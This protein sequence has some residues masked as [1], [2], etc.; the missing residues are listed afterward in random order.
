MV[1]FATTGTP[2]LTTSFSEQCWGTMFMS[3]LRRVPASS[4]VI[5][6]AAIRDNFAC[7]FASL[8]GPLAPR[9]H[10][11]GSFFF[12]SHSK[13][14]FS[15]SARPHT[16]QLPRLRSSADSGDSG[17]LTR[18]ILACQSR[19]EVLALFESFQSSI[20]LDRIHISA[21]FTTLRKLGGKT[22]ASDAR[23]IKLVELAR[24]RFPKA[25]GRELATVIHR[26]GQLGAT[27]SGEWIAGFWKSSEAKL[28]DFSALDFSSTMHACSRLGLTPPQPWLAV[29]WKSSA[30]KLSGFDAKGLAN[31]LFAFSKLSLAPPQPWMDSFM[32]ALAI[33]KQ[34]SSPTSSTSS[35]EKEVH[36]FLGAAESKGAK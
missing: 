33:L 9:P 16:M 31:T 4:A 13:A 25:D 22:V 5:A 17:D 8:P 26:C 19:D 27:L 28:S 23:F 15:Q 20:G 35:L 21:L 29:F 18:A 14:F 12:T 6:R 2:H 10:Q 34:S 11:S 36:K 1:C 30:A 3:N 7:N 24:S 32:A